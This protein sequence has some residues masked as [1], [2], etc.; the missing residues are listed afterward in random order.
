LGINVVAYSPL[1]RGLLTGTVRDDQSS[2]GNFRS[3][4][5]RFSGDAIHTNLSV[6]DE[7][8]ELARVNGCTTG[9]LCL[10]WLLAQGSDV[11]AIPGSR[12]TQRLL[13]NAA[14]ATIEL[15]PE[16]LRRIDAVAGR[17]RWAGDR[18]SF[19]AVNTS[20]SDPPPP[21]AQGPPA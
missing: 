8:S 5:P 10:A 16:T 9:Q 3:S 1:G 7:L 18:Q 17:D 14:A 11:Y 21:S 20:R 12:R 4:D 19:A 15:P 2:A 6:V 13:E